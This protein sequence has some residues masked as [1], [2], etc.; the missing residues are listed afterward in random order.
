M[1]E[2]FFHADRGAVFPLYAI[3][4]LV[5]FLLDFNL[6]SNERNCDIIDCIFSFLPSSDTFLESV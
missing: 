5:M 1:A 2:V 6:K 4:F 3:C